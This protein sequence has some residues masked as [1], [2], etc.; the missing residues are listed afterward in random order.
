METRHLHCMTL[1]CCFLT[2]QKYKKNQFDKITKEKIL[3][4]QVMR[5]KFNS[6][7]NRIKSSRDKKATLE[8]WLF[9]FACAFVEL[10]KQEYIHH[11]FLNNET[12]VQKENFGGIF[13]CFEVIFVQNGTFKMIRRLPRMKKQRFSTTNS[14]FSWKKTAFFDR[15]NAVFFRSVFDMFARCWNTIFC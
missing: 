13:S 1:Q 7:T 2:V 9:S 8:E 12:R 4:L 11:Y 15:K 3:H 5:R 6:S 14:S 10:I